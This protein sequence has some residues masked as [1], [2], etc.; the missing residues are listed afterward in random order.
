MDT[1]FTHKRQGFTLIELLVVV[2]IIAILAAML[3]PALESAREAARRTVC[4]G[5]LK[6]WSVGWGAYFVDHSQ[7]LRSAQ[8]P[9]NSGY[10]R[11]QIVWERHSAPD[12]FSGEL[13]MEAV[14]RYIGTPFDI[15]NNSVRAE[16]LVFCPSTDRQFKAEWAENRMSGWWGS[17]EGTR[18]SYGYYGR[19]S[20]WTDGLKNG[21]ELELVDTHPQAGNRLLMS[22][23]LRWHPFTNSFDSNH[24]WSGSSWGAEP[25]VF[26]HTQIQGLN[27]LYGDGHAKWLDSS[28]MDTAS[29]MYGESPPVP[30]FPYIVIDGW[31]G[32]QFFR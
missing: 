10:H 9:W 27:Q 17:Y 19:V 2:A 13:N 5:N 11:P 8:P 29:M 22:D 1:V 16:S 7:P 21:A 14:N 32:V 30:D 20:D 31:G 15:A 18:M 6:Q 24:P 25:A 3:M 4:L 23:V 12:E 28:R 26:D